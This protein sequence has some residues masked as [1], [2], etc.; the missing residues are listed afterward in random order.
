MGAPSYASRSPAET[1]QIVFLLNL[2]FTPSLLGQ[3]PIRHCENSQVTQYGVRAVGRVSTTMEG[4]K[5]YEIFGW[6]VKPVIIKPGK[7]VV[8][9]RMLIEYSVFV[10]CLWYLFGEEVYRG[11]NISNIVDAFSLYTNVRPRNDDTTES[12]RQLSPDT[13]YYICRELAS[14]EAC[15]GY[16]EQCNIRYYASF[17]QRIKPACPYCKDIV[18]SGNFVGLA[19]LTGS[20]K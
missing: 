18:G 13:I 17:D 2:G 19:Y 12:T 16:C 5:A 9:N 11:L 14:Q 20:A 3:A 8:S 10:S 15:I 4:K 7:G 1:L 6:P